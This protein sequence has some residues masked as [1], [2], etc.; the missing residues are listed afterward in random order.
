MPDAIIT[1]TESTFG[2]I[3]GTFAAD[4]STIVGTVTGGITGNLSGSVGVPG[5]AGVG[6][7]AGGLEGQIIVKASDTSYDTVWVDNAAETL[8]AT[9][10]NETGATLT[11]GTVVYINGA[12]GNKATVTKASA[13]S[14]ASSSKT[15]GIL[16]ADIAN[17]QN[18][19]AVTV[20]LL[21][22]VNTSAFTAGANLWLSTT[23]GEITQTPPV[24]PNHAVFLGNATRI[25][26]NQGEIEVRIQNG[27]E[28]G[29]LHDVLI[30]TPTNGQVLKYD[31]TTSLWKNQTDLNSGVWGSITGTLSSQTDL[32]TALDGKAN[33][34][35]ATFTGKVIGTATA[36]DAAFNIGTVAVAPTTIVNGDVWITDR[37]AFRNRF[38]NTIT[39]LTNNQTNTIVTSSPSTFILGIT[40]NGNGGGLRVV[41]N[42]TGDSFRVE[43]E[44][45]ES[46]P[47]VISNLGRVGIGVTPDATAAL[48]VDTNGIMFGDDTVQTT[49]YPGLSILDGYAT[50]SWVTSQGYL[51]SA[52]LIGY[53]TEEWVN[54]QGFLTSTAGLALLAGSD[55]TGRVTVPGI[56]GDEI[57][58]Y[59]GFNIV[60]TQTEPTD[61]VDGDL[62]VYDDDGLTP[63]KLRV[64][65]EG[66]TQNIATESWVTTTS[67]FAPLASPLFTGNPR[68]PTPATSDNDTS[69]ATTAFVKAQG[70]AP[71]ATAD[72]LIA[73]LSSSAS[74]GTNGYRMAGL[75]TNI[76]A[77]SVPNLSSLASGAGSNIGSSYTA[78]SGRLLAPS[79]ATAGYAT[80]GFTLHFPSNN[81]GAGAAYN[82]STESGHAVRVYAG[83]WGS[84]V[85]GVK[86]RGVFGR[87]SGTIPVPATLAARAYGWEWN[88]STRTMNIIVHNGTTL[89]TTA[90]TWNPISSRTYEIT[91]TSNGAG[92]ISLYVD[93]VLLGTSSGGP[94]GLNNASNIWWQL[95]IQNEVTA[96]AQL[97][98]SYQNPKVY[99]SNG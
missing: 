72:Q 42:G 59:P 10:R 68:G 20:G 1:S 66:N 27:L 23:A 37:L 41:N 19:T 25:H 80:R 84:T 67:G 5:P 46:T 90:V 50:E 16:S 52:N 48:K 51:T 35:G 31:S 62:W 44:T 97:D 73:A 34:S 61:K 88:W 43:D 78:M 65:L 77:P 79:A 15:F 32:Q 60:P 7:P 47:F 38:G 49:A 56:T 14:E 54:S 21:K 92:T 89:T 12:S 6:V 64:F 13:S 99:T 98:C 29:E 18:G 30:T 82:F 40:Q 4:Q 81:A 69:L 9:V 8:T 95:E 22:K 39:A 70:Y 75:T 83:G 76:W 71:I 33:L 36:A 26:V 86:M 45:P 94:T 93:G 57:V 87:M 53:A 17:N 91:C 96:G 85:A 24:S 11:K 28:L 3:S 2:T 63:S 55:F 58:N 74:V